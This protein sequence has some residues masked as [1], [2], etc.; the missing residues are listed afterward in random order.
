MKKNFIHQTPEEKM[1]NSSAETLSSNQKTNELLQQAANKPVPK[2][3]QL[4]TAFFSMLA[5]QDGKEGPEGPEGQQGPQGP[6]GPM[7]LKG[8]RGDRG[9]TGFNGRDGAPGLAGSPDTPDEVVDKVN[10]STKKIKTEKVQGLKEAIAQLNTIGNSPTGKDGVDIGGGKT[11]RYLAGGSEVSAHVTELNFST[12]LT[13]TYAGDGRITLT[14]AGGGSGDVTK[15]GT[16]VD[17]Q[18]GVWTGDGTIEGDTAL[19]FDTTTNTLATGIITASTAGTPATFTNT[20]DSASAAGLV[21]QGDRAT[22]ANNDEVMIEMKLSD[23]AGN[24]DEFARITAR[25]VDVTSTSEDG[26]MRFGVVTA[27]TFGDRLLLAGTYLAPTPSDGLALGTTTAQFS[28]LFLAEGGVINWDNGDVTLTQSGNTLNVAGGSFTASTA[29][30]PATFTNT[31]DSISVQGL[32]VQGD[33]ATPGV[34]DSVYQSFQLS[35]NAGNQSEFARLSAAA[36]S[37]V[38]GSENGALGFEIAVS[39]VMTGKL[40]LYG[41]SFVPTVNDDLALGSTAQS[42]SDL[43]L[44]E[45]GVINWDNGDATLTQVGNTVTLAGADL[46]VTT[47]GTAAN[48]SGYTTSYTNFN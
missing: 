39:G 43:F 17:N 38:N 14:A 35:D 42:F 41:N 21:I 19:T 22:V 11:V 16:P 40:L 12:G 18:V 45:G 4:A 32:I 31:T 6:Q 5:G 47:A 10:N 7:G 28:D 9:E 30:T 1:A 46:L 33:R 44:A 15:V 8:D 24:Q 29:G 20:T 34:Y 3:M 27:G 37:I 13:A 2:E 36:F 26:Q 25:A 48:F 23:S